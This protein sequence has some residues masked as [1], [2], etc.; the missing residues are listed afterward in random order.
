MKKIRQ[1]RPKSHGLNRL[2]KAIAAV[3]VSISATMGAFAQQGQPGTVTG[4]VLDSNN[5]PVVGA[6]VVVVGT[7]TGTTTGIDGTFELRASEGQQLEVSFVGMSTELVPVSFNPITVVLNEE[8]TL[9]DEAVVIGYGTAKKR[10]LTGSIVNVDAEDI[11]NRPS[12]NPLASLQGRVAGVQ[13][14]NTGRAGQDPEIRIRGTN[15]INGYAPLYVVDGLFTDNI[16]FLNAN[17]IDSFEILKDPSSLAIFGVRGANGVIIITTK[18][19]KEGQTIVNVNQSVGIKHVGHRLSLTNGAQF[20]ELYNEQLANMGSDPFDYTHYSA[21]TDWQDAI[22]QNAVISQ[23]TASVSSSDERNN[24]YLG[25]GYTYEQGNILNEEMQ[26]VTINFS[27]DY[28]MKDWLKFGVQMNGAYMMPADAK[29]VTGAIHAAPISPIYAENGDYYQLPSF[30]SAQ[31]S[32]PMVDIE[33]FAAHNKAQNYRFAG[34][35]YGE[36]NFFPQ[37][38]FRAAFSLDYA[39]DNSRQYSPVIY[40]YDPATGE[41][42]PRSQTESISQ[43]KSNTLNAQQDYT[44]TYTNTFAEK[45]NLTLMAG[46][47]TN[48]TSYESLTAGR[49]QN[50][51]TADITIPND[52][53]DKWWISSIGDTS[54]A[55]NGGSQ[56]RKFTMS[57]L[58][59]ALYNYDNRYLLNA[60][61]RRDGASVFKYTGNTWDNFYSVG[62]GWI[63]SEE[64]FMRN[65]DVIDYLK[66]KGSYGVLGNQNIGS[67]GGNYPAFPTLNTSNAV[68]GDNIISSF[69]QAY[70]ATDLGWEKTKAWEVG[71]EIQLLNQRLHIEPTYYSKTTEDLICYLE[72]FMGAQDGLIN[73]GSLRNR[74]FE[75]SGSW[76]DKIGQDFRYTLSGNLTT[77]DNE[78]LSLGKTYYEGDKSVAVSEPGRPIGYFYGYVV[79]G[80]YQNAADIASSPTNTL[81]TAAPGDLKFKDI[82][83][84]GQITP[85][86][87]TMIGNPT[88]DFTYGYSLNLQYKNF[89]LGIDFQGVYGNEIY[90]TGFLSAYAQYNYNTK[91]LDRWNGE[92]TSNWEPI[93]DSSRSLQ[94]ENSNYYIEDGSYLRLKNIQIGYSFSERLLKRIRV[95]ALRLFF[96]IDNLKTWAYNTGYTPEIGGS[97]LAFGIDTGSTYPMPTTYTFGVNLSF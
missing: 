20:R 75:L 26:K 37:L 40:E 24:F 78:V 11:A 97:A 87:R 70:L 86:D 73:A 28:K 17:D 22:F 83:G 55:T 66:V 63:V 27:D 53:P 16:N 92:G 31:L 94:M 85:D 50:I 42:N 43:T 65:Q 69:S 88:P 80:V 93:L 90:N 23:T 82:N 10:D 36:I 25:V 77:I 45:H 7:V 18:R 48:Y 64:S 39:S 13:I 1:D 91:R 74:G 46:M 61:F 47:T 68:F 14:T 81:A 12:S 76:S 72:S 57:Y 3:I 89:D 32:N 44:L 56:Y 62:A 51:T 21:D 6:S 35:V 30:Q 60:S 52:D 19:A 9:I 38:K 33:E 54:T 34:N 5:Q 96:N 67:A 59:R 84:D 95:K 49:S 4:K 58:F 8:S 41:T 71:V 29:N 15:S 2:F 79:E